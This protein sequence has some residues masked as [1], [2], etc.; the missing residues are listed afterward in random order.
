MTTMMIVLEWM[1]LNL[2]LLLLLQIRLHGVH[3]D[4]RIRM[5]VGTKMISFGPFRKDWHPLNH[6]I[7]LVIIK[8]PTILILTIIKIFIKVIRFHKVAS[9]CRVHWKTYNDGCLP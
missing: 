2:L 1:I 5:R 6:I 3:H 8:Y 7:I 4:D 9:L